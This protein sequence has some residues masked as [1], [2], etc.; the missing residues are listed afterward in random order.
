MQ[1]IRV[2]TNPTNEVFV[3]ACNQAAEHALGEYLLFLNNDTEV[4]TGWLPAMLAP[5]SEPKTGIVGAKLVYPDGRLQEA[6]GI[7]W[8]DGSG[9]NYGH[10]DNP[11]FPQYGYR[12]AVDYCSGACLM[13][14]NSLWTEIGGFDQRY[15]PAYYEDTD[16]C[17]T[18]RSLKY[19]VIY[20][21]N[22]RIIH[23]G[24]ASAGKETSSGYKR[25]QDINRLKFIEKW[26]SV[27][28][29]DHYSS[30]DNLAIS[31]EK[32][33]NK[34]V[35]VIDHKVPRPDQD[36]G[37]VRMLGILRVLLGMGYRIYFWP[38]DLVYEFKYTRTLQ[39]LG[40][41]TFYGE[42][43]FDTF[44][45]EYGGILDA[46][47]LSRPLTAL[48]YF[49]LVKKYSNAKTI[50]DTVDLH[51]IREQRRGEFESRKLKELEFFLANE[52]DATLVVSATEKTLLAEEE[53]SEKVSIV[54]NIHS[55]EPCLN[56]FEDRKGLMFIG[57]FAHA[58]N[59][60]GIFWF[61]DRLLPIIA[62]KIPDI[63]IT[64]VGSQPTERLLSL[65]NHH[66]TVAGYV[67]DVSEYFNGSRV[68]VSPLL[69][70][71]GVKGKI[72]QSFSY[73]LPVVTTSIGAEGINLIDGHNALIADTEMEFASKV[74]ELYTDKALWQKISK[75]C[76]Q[77]IKDQFGADTIQRSLEQIL[78]K[79]N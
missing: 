17:F 35:L 8:Q 3:N 62:K 16:L 30:S 64:I 56:G 50:Y 69:Y 6:G 53:F 72:G 36:S 9:C 65:I 5:F 24:G 41:E 7:I 40:I 77:V 48:K 74:I 49:H 52:T 11:D 54:S 75:N 27:L 28:A 47:I 79:D 10:G 66:V 39:D 76:Q 31:R 70:G 59:E 37:S 32:N 51:Y 42:W 38:G 4:T 23:F 15:A 13:I 55:L 21:P 60:E 12:K 43:E 68:F 46:V 19:D 20:Q 57:G 33:N 44:I 29:E 61:I 73:G 22:A 45:K 14:S 71:S 26:G 25:Y 63:H 78:K 2:I 18:V 1:G 34:H 58:P 67:E